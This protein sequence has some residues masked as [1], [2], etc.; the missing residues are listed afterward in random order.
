MTGDSVKSLF[1][2]IFYH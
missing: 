1:V 2:S